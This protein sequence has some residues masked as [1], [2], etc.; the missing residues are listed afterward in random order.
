MTEGQV[1][2]INENVLNTNNT[3]NK[4]LSYPIQSTQPEH[5]IELIKNAGVVGAGGAGFPTYVK[6]NAKVDTLIINAAECEPLIDVDKL[7][8]EHYFEKVY[9]GIVVAADLIGAKRVV[10]ALKAKYKKQIEIIKKFKEKIGKNIN[11]SAVGS[12]GLTASDSIAATAVNKTITSLFRN[13]NFEIFELD[14]FYPAGDEQVLVYLVTSRIVPEGGIPLMVGVVV[15]NVETLLNVSNALKNM[16]VIEKYLTINGLVGS[17]KTLKV[18]VGTPV[19]LLLEFCNIDKAKSFT[20][21]DGGP[22][23]GKIIDADNYAVKKT[24]KSILVLPTENIVI[25][26]KLR[27]KQNQV[28]RAQAI[29]LSCRMCTDLCPRY[30]LGHSLFPDELMKKMYKG[31]LNDDELEKFSFSYLCCDCGVCELYSCPV[32]LSPRSLL[33]Y[34]KE[35]L[36]QLGVKNPH[37]R[38]D[39]KQ[40]EFIDYRRVPV[41][42]LLSRLNLTEFDVKTGLNDF[43]LNINF[44]K[45]YL[46]QHIG[47]KS[48]PVVSV[49]DKVN[50]GQVIAKIPE[51]KI[52]S[53]IHSSINGVVKEINDEFIIIE[54]L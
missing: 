21:L 29:C 2:N 13:V 54:R 42:R 1:Q 22:M 48:N 11:T 28:K 49:G 50:R 53:N 27:S 52:G 41:Q 20:V 46:S 45:L 19:K 39:L 25:S 47:A 15:S 37:T 51:G 26:Q 6:Y 7:L 17:P 8:I 4:N 43:D 12:E 40:N 18:P 24:T 9:E 14:N 36:A 34:I 3:N 5:I 16:P 38:K 44:V 30:L 23:M 32:D 10:I 31:T 33:Q 35:R